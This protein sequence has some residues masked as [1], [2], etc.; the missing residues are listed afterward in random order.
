[1]P[2]FGV[3][4]LSAHLTA[5]IVPTWRSLSTQDPQRREALRDIYPGVSVVAQAEGV[6]HD[7]DIEAVVIATPAVTHYDL[8]VAA[9]D[10]GKHVLIEKPMTTSSA[11]ARALTRLA[12]ARGLTLMVGHVFV[13]NSA[14][15]AIGKILEEGRLGDLAYGCR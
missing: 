3:P 11:D 12:E 14:V 15:Q 8:A 9:L 7:P 5:L 13:Y 6:L 4:S 10:A 1:M 2:D